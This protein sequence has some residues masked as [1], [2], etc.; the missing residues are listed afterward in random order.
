MSHPRQILRVMVETPNKIVSIA[1]FRAARTPVASPPVSATARRHLSPRG[2][3]H[4]ERMLHFL[5]SA[6]AQRAAGVESVRRPETYAAREEQ[7]RLLL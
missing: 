2:I 5:R 7:G 3:E 1:A 6:A 4:R